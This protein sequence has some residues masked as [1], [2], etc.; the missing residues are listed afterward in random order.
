MENH[1]KGEQITNQVVCKLS[2]FVVQ[3]VKTE[4]INQA[5]IKLSAS[6][7]ADQANNSEGESGPETTTSTAVPK[8]KPKVFCWV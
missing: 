6:P 2:L 1:A 3:V 8:S 5:R 4:Y 7:L